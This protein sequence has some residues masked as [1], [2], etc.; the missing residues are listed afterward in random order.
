MTV[1]WAYEDIL[2][3]LGLPPDYFPPS[4]DEAGVQYERALDLL[5]K[6]E[7]KRGYH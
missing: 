3:R 4:W 5:H 7:N 1:G 6:P 2:R